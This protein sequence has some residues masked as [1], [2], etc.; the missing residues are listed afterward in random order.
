MQGDSRVLFQG[1]GFRDAECDS[2]LSLVNKYLP[3]SNLG[4]I[5]HRSV[6]GSVVGFVDVW[7]GFLGSR[8]DLVFVN[9]TGGVLQREVLELNRGAEVEDDVLGSV[10]DIEAALN[11]L[12]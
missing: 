9:L 12:A 4:E 10:L 8:R 1:P 3:G 11:A 7:F 2:F 6:F 5:F